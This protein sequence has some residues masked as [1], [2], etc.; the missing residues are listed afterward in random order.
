MKD[1]LCMVFKTAYKYSGFDSYEQLAEAADVSDSTVRKFMC[2]IVT[3]PKFSTA[4]AMASAINRRSG[5]T[6]ISI[7]SLIGGD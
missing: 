2:G 5:E 7:D 3:D 6:L 1:D 4:A